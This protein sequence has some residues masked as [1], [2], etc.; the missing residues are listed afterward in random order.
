MKKLVNYSL[1]FKRT[2][3]VVIVVYKGNITNTKNKLNR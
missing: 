2:R 3:K 1:K